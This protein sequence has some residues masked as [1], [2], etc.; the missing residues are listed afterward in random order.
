MSND[1]DHFV[2]KYLV[3]CDFGVP[4]VHE[5]LDDHRDDTIQLEINLV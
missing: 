2:D 3:G 1:L 5:L 4:C